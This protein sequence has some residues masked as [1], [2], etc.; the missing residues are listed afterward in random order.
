[1]AK[2]IDKAVDKLISKVTFE[3]FLNGVNKVCFC[4]LLIA[5]GYVL[6]H[7]ANGL[8]FIG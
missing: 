5:I 3:E 7:Y 1:M 6:C 8:H 2:L 4:A